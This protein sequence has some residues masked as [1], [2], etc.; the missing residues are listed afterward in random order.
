MPTLMKAVLYGKD[1]G[2][3]STADR[4]CPVIPTLFMGCA[5]ITTAFCGSDQAKR[6]EHRLRKGIGEERDSE[7]ILNMGFAS[8]SFRNAPLQAVADVSS[9]PLEKPTGS[10]ASDLLCRHALTALAW[11]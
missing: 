9:V 8:V 7:H 5:K 11:M 6:C 2:R 1:V 3:L 10:M 4:G